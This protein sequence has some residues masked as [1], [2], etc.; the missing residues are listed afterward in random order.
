MKRVR[1]TIDKDGNVKID[2][3]GFQGAECEQATAELEASLGAPTNRKLKPERS[4]ASAQKVGQ[5]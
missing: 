5:K 2:A 4:R 3:I 1:V